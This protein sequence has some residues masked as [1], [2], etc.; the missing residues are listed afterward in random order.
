MS[1]EI[2]QVE[3]AT[4]DKFGERLRQLRKSLGLSQTAFGESLG[5]VSLATIT[6]LERGIFKPQAEFLARLALTYDCDLR[7]L[8]IGDSQ[9]G[10]S[11]STFATSQVTRHPRIYN[12]LK[13][14]RTEWMDI[15]EKTMKAVDGGNEDERKMAEENI[16]VYREG[17][18]YLEILLEIGVDKK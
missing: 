1:D 18:D 2:I 7:A 17:I 12:F 14:Q 5:G 9:G 3:F 8:L 11:S 13:A 6:R 16:K 15:V 10:G 4:C